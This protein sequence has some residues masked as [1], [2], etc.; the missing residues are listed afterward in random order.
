MSTEVVLHIPGLTG[1]WPESL[2]AQVMVLDLPQQIQKLIQGRIE[3]KPTSS[4]L[5]FL[6]QHFNLPPHTPWAA[7][8]L[9]GEG[10]TIDKETGS[11]LKLETLNSQLGIAHLSPPLKSVLFEDAKN[12]FGWAESIL[13]TPAGHWYLQLEPSDFLICQPWWKAAQRKKTGSA[14]GL[15]GKSAAKWERRLHLLSQK[16]AHHPL[17]L[18]AMTSTPQRAFTQIWPWGNAPFL[19]QPMRGYYSAIYSDNPIYRGM[20]RWLQA[21]TFPRMYASA[22][23]R[24]TLVNHPRVCLVLDELAGLAACGDMNQWLSRLLE[25][26]LRVIKPL[27]E[28][29]ELGL[30]DDLRIED[31]RQYC[32]HYFA[33][34]RFFGWAKLQT[35]PWYFKP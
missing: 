24:Q 13:Q 15:T 4:Y 26:D 30:V 5:N 31:G 32:W 12:Q 19:P 28:A 29:V 22:D 17:N 14:Y 25:I 2:R 35:I 20:A 3:E 8:G 27:M 10:I 1:P 6:K 23:W 9:V 34:Q 7:Y 11:W 21:S 16:L 33:R 18:A